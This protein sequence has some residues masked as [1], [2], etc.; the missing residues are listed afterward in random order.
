MIRRVRL[1]NFDTIAPA[2]TVAGI[3]GTVPHETMA[4]IEEARLQS[5]EKGYKAGWDDAAAAH[6][7]EQTHISSE[8]GRNLQDMSFTY[9]EAHAALV[10]E[11]EG[12][13]RG[14][15]DKILPGTRG[16]ALSE[17]I[18][19]RVVAATRSA[20]LAAEVTV[21]PDMVSRVNDLLSGEA[22]LPV[23]IAAEASLAEGQA[24]LRLG[25]TEEAIDVDAVLSELSDV[26]DRFLSHDAEAEGPAPEHKE[27][28]NG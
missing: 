11:I 25:A 23:R 20:G 2:V 24:Y 12:L 8:L 27:V 14:V 13:L 19:S 15:F 1:E 7:D 5:F 4:D 28:S 3:P 22:A 9:H 18:L 16:L 26:V 10:R 17:L 21:A 6:S